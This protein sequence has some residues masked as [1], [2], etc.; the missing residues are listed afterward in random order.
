M[1]CILMR[2]GI[3]AE[4]ESWTGSDETRPL[5]VQGK[6]KVRQAAAGLAAMGLAPTHLLSSPLTRAK[7]TAKLLRTVLCPSLPLIECEQLVPGSSPHQLAAVLA[8]LPAEAVVLCVGHEPLMGRAASYLLTGQLLDSFPMKK[9]G[10]AFIHF[11]G[12]VAAGQ[13]LLR[14]WCQPSQLRMVRKDTRRKE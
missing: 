1:D 14:W 11:D 9:A 10:A 7:E 6:K 2:H 8:D 4:P 13:G 12:N 5:T 3:A